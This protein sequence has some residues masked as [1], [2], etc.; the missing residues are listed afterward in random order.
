VRLRFRAVALV[1]A[2][3]C[4]VL[5]A[6]WLAAPRLLLA[7]WDLPLDPAARVMALR[8]AALYLGLGVILF[9]A[10]GQPPSPARRALAVGSAVVCAALAIAAVGSLAAGLAG[11]GVLI[12]VVVEVVAAAAFILTLRDESG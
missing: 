12:P 4:G 8:T 10:R 1:L 11:P 5:A 3:F 7:T 2:V 6:G 9:L